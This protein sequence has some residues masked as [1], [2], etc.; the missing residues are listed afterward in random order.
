MRALNVIENALWDVCPNER[1]HLAV[2]YS[3]FSIANP[4]RSIYK[5]SNKVQTVQ[6]V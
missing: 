2:P 3:K 5:Q 1:Y 6:K 4:C